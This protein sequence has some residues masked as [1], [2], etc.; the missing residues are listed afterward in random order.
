MLKGLFGAKSIRRPDPNAALPRHNFA[1]PTKSFLH[2]GRT[3]L[4]AAK[5]SSAGN[6]PFFAANECS[7]KVN[8]TFFKPNPT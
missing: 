7:V 3:L 1:L 2:R 4:S 5:I 6:S 8:Q